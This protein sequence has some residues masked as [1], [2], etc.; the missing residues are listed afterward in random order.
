MPDAWSR[1]EVR[2]IVADYFAMFEA[3]LRAEDYVKSHHRRALAPRLDDRS[4]GSIERKH[5]NISAAL[6]E[7]GWPYIDGYKP[8]PNYQS[9][10]RDEI[11]RFLADRLDLFDLV[12][13]DVNAEAEVP[14][15]EDILAAWDTP[16]KPSQGDRTSD[17]SDIVYAPRIK[18]IDYL[19]QEARNQSLGL[20]GEQFALRF[21][22]AR[23]IHEGLDR[24]ADQVEHVSV[25]QGDGAG[26]DIL[27]FEEDGAERFIEVKTT[28]Y[29]KD[30][31]FYATANEVRFSENYRRQYHLYRCFGFRKAGR[32]YTADGAI[33]EVSEMTAA[34]YVCR[35]A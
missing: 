33:S 16:P 24:Y 19:A 18:K 3:E 32:L 11:E 9:L 30:T 14:S 34:S 13:K 1:D 4:D 31:P 7:L 28:K 20:A 6:V 21:E 27:S 35:P 2:A 15:V 22:Q 8:L 10:L 29:G 17:A 25:T 5:M 26:F 12:E 23:L